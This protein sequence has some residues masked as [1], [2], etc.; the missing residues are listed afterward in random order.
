MLAVKVACLCVYKNIFCIMY[1]S[2]CKQ[3][4]YSINLITL[5]GQITLAG[6]TRLESW[7]GKYVLDS[8]IFGIHNHLV[9]RK[10]RRDTYTLEF[11]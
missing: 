2:L 8:R 1:I 7:K 5:Y 4:N 3:I 11:F 6:F 9:L 10:R